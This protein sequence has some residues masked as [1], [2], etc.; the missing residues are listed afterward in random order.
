MTAAELAR[1]IRDHLDG[2]YADGLGEDGAHLSVRL[3]DLGEVVVT[4]TCAVG[5]G[6]KTFR[7]TFEEVA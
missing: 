2:E 3:G 5:N 1:E 7:A 6:E 4:V